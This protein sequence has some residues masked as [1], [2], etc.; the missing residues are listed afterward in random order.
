MDWNHEFFHFSDHIARSNLDEEIAE[1]IRNDSND[2]LDDDDDEDEE[3]IYE[4]PVP[5]KAKKNLTRKSKKQQLKQVQQKLYSCQICDRSFS[6]LSKLRSCHQQCKQTADQ[7]KSKQKALTTSSVVAAPK[8]AYDTPKSNTSTKTSN[9][10]RCC[11]VSI[12][13][14]ETMLEHC[15]ENHSDEMIN[16]NP[17]MCDKCDLIFPNNRIIGKKNNMSCFWLQN[18]LNFG[19]QNCPHKKTPSIGSIITSIN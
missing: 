8:S 3:E 12:D 15:Q 1:K 2:D 19:L 17:K 13:T 10:F 5:K 18:Q 6:V 16:Q 11:G 9:V 7:Q 4:P 14:I